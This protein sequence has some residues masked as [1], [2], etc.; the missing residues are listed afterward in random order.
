MFQYPEHQIFEETVFLDV[1][2]GPSNLGLKKSEVELRAYEA[3]KLTGID[4]DCYDLSPLELSGG[5]RRRLAI[6]G[7]IAMRPSV[8]ILDEPTAGLDPRGAKDILDMVSAIRREHGSAIVMVSHNMEEVAER[9][10][11]IVV[12]NGGTIALEGDRVSVFS[13]VKE[14][15]A[16]GLKLPEVT[17]IMY[18]L[19]DKG[20]KIDTNALTTGEAVEAVI[21]ATPR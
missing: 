12:M 18:M 15:K 20:L 16:L 6:A 4:E 19:K 1:C 3:L 17:E 2:F 13:H 21:H 11:R 9:S 14:L 5:L 10:E 7:V 8:L